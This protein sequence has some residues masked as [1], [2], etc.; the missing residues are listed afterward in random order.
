MD[1]GLF[2]DYFTRLYKS[3]ALM[4]ADYLK[5][6]SCHERPGFMV[7]TKSMKDLASFF[8]CSKE[9]KCL[10]KGFDDEYREKPS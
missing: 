1:E 5:V 3:L 9:H 10:D 2:R 8:R 4:E 6:L 7:F